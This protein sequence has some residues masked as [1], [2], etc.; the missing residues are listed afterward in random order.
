MVVAEACVCGLSR[1]LINSHM[2]QWGAE[3]FLIC[4]GGLDSR[5]FE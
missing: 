2:A 3:V 1:K 4:N 5:S